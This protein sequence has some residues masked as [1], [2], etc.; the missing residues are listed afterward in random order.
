MSFSDVKNKSQCLEHLSATCLILP[1]GQ[2]NGGRP[3]FDLQNKVLITI[4]ILGNHKCLRSVADRFN[5]KKSILIS[6]LPQNLR[7]D[8][9]QSFRSIYEVRTCLKL[10]IAGQND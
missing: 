6:C 7:I 2:R 8:G 10:S 3:T 4:W 5:I 9:Q 1:H